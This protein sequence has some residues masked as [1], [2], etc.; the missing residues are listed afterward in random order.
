MARK[1]TRKTFITEKL[2]QA[3]KRVSIVKKAGAKVNPEKEREYNQHKAMLKRAVENKNFSAATKHAAKLHVLSRDIERAAQKESS[4]KE[5]MREILGM[6]GNKKRPVMRPLKS[7][8]P[9]LEVIEIDGMPVLKP[10]PKKKATS[11]P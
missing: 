9:E 3:D 7:K 2:A 1:I 4:V 8:L 11:T 10:L 5:Q 6:V